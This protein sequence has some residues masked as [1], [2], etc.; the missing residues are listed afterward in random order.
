[1]DENGLPIT[2]AGV[3]YAAVRQTKTNND[4][5]SVE[6]KINTFYTFFFLNQVEAINQRELVTYINMFLIRTCAFLNSF[7]SKCES[8]LAEL[9]TR[10]ESI[11]TSIT[12]LETKVITSK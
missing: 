7:S 4:L 5:F 12:L 6:S 8:K 11:D 1:M 9:H 3:N 10:L 2:G